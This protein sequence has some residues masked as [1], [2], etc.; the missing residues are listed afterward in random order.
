MTAFLRCTH[1]LSKPQDWLQRLQVIAGALETFRLFMRL[2]TERLFTQRLF[3]DALSRHFFAANFGGR[4]HQ[5]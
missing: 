5:G 3:F 1:T 2:E 4:A